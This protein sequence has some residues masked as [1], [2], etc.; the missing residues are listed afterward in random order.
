VPTKISKKNILSG[1]LLGISYIW[2]KLI[3]IIQAPISPL[4]PN[5]AESLIKKDLILTVPFNVCI[6]YSIEYIL[7]SFSCSLILS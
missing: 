4:L 3:C 1:A 6:V 2:S 5:L 7:G